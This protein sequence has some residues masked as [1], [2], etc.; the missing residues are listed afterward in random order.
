MEA[1]RQVDGWPCGQ[2]AVAVVYPDG[3]AATHGDLER[4]FPWASVTKLATSVAALVAT[5]EGIVSLDEP[6]GPPG[7]TLRH[8]LAHASGLPLDGDAPI[9]APGTRRI[10]SNAGFEALAAHIAEAAGMPFAEYFESVWS[11]PLGGSPAHGVEGPL[12]QLVEVARELSFPR[13]LARA[14]LEEA[15]AVQFPGLDG[16]LPGFGRFGPNDWGLGLELRDGKH[17]HWT[18]ERNSPATFG[19]FGRAGG[20]LWVDPEAG[21]ALACL[22]DLDF[23]DWAK[24][25]WPRLSDA[26]LGDSR[27]APAAVA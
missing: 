14:T 15:A 1:L 27:R 12:T 7:S 10:Y 20:F 21:L 19:H 25:A 6:A 18:G 11:F 24:D 8:L 22:T 26:V 17:P 9:A 4:P 2:A 16:V 23:G 13:R 3:A 5:E